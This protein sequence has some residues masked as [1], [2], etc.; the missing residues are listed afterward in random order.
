MSKNLKGIG[1]G[2]PHPLIA[3][4]D[5]F[6][7]S[8]GLSRSE[9]IRLSV[10]VGLPLLKLGVA[11]NTRRVLSILEYGQMALSMMV[12]REYP[13]DHNELLDMALRNVEEYHG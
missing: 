10:T 8:K 7:E 12:E 9:A 5:A 1:V 6:C 4:L 3:D 13:E 2:L 11:V